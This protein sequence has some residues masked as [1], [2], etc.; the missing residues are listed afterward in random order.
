MK[1][2]SMMLRSVSKIV[3]FDPQIEKLHILRTSGQDV[4]ENRAN[5]RLRQIHV[6][7]Q[8]IKR[9]L[10]FDHPKLRQMPR[11]VGVLRP[12]R[13]AERITIADGTGEDLRFEL[14]ADGQRRLFA[15]EI[16]AVINLRFQLRQ[17]GEVER[18]HL[19]HRA[20]PLAVAGGD[21]RRVDVQE[22]SRLKEIVNGGAQGIPHAG[23]G[24]ECI[25]PR[26]QVRDL[27]QELEAVPLF[28]QRI[29]LSIRRTEYR[30]FRRVQFDPLSFAGG[31]LE[32]AGDAHAGAGGDRLDTF[33]E[34]GDRVVDDHLQAPHRTAVVEFQKGERLFRFPFGA[35]PAGDF[36]LLRRLA[37]FE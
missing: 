19:K 17:L 27:P 21:D 37:I 4:G 34:A 3:V 25:R 12:E 31:L 10:R 14:P 6:V 32:F 11:R 8:L 26:P 23:D 20:G 5:K 28:L 1:S 24:S 7:A 22:S 13:G 33:G 36:D 2:L 15:E 16:L 9:H 29:R 35:D 30:Q 18:R